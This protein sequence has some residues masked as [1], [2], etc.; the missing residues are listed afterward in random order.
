MTRKSV[1]W[2]IG[3]VIGLAGTTA[4]TAAVMILHEPDFYR[5][6]A[7]DVGEDRQRWSAE[8]DEE[9]SSLVNGII[10]YKTWGARFTEQQVNS[11]LEEGFSRVRAPERS[12]F[13]ER[14]RQPRLAFEEDRIRIGFRYGDRWWSPVISLDLKVWLARGEPNVVALQLESMRAGALPI[15]MQSILE[16]FSEAMRARDIEMTWYRHA[17][18]PVAL[19]RFGPS[20]KDPSVQLMRVKVQAGVLSVQGADRSRP[21]RNPAGAATAAK[22]SV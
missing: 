22:R 14:V 6:T 7:I 12:L 17:N 18:R 9:L 11:Y 13:P 1:L 2:T 16:R 10:N 15:T 3:I 20:R 21:A 4:G 8:F 19:V 5:R